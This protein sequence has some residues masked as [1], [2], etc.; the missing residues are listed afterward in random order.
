VDTVMCHP[1]HPLQS[2]D[3]H[4]PTLN[5]LAAESSELCPSLRIALQFSSVQFSRSVV[6]DPWGKD[7]PSLKVMLPCW[8]HSASTLWSFALK[9]VKGLTPL[10]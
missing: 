7:I 3:A 4:F 10:T 6:S 8:E 1:D 5:I 9:G 2:Q